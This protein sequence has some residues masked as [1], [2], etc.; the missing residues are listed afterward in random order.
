[1]EVDLDGE[2]W[3]L[4]PVDAV[5]RAGLAV[6]RSLDRETARTLARELRRARAIERA[7]RAL[8]VRD[9]SRGALDERLTRAGVPAAT[10]EE[11][12]ATLERIG[13]IDDARVAGAR[14]SAL[15]ERGY[16]DAAIRADLERQRVGADI[17]RAALAAL[18]PERDRARRIVERHG[19]EPR[20]VRRLL[21]RGFEPEVVSDTAGP[22]AGFANDT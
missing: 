7:T 1:V 14:A 20:V 4:V 11:T 8:V 15:A 2:P 6:G 21:A 19:L 3:R 9:R 16:G 13:A 22:G 10:R 17:V 5:A 12:L 18:E